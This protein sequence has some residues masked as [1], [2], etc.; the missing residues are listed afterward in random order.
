VRGTLAQFAGGNEFAVAKR[1]R[2]IA[3][4]STQLREGCL[5]CPSVVSAV[6]ADGEVEADGAFHR[7]DLVIGVDG[8]RSLV[9]RTLWPAESAVNRTG[10]TSRRHV[11]FTG[12]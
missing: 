5:R 2:L 11:T 7:F 12:T 1:S 9:R 6:T 10:R 8:A 4:L 3:A